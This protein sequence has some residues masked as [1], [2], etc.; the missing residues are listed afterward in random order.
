VIL[1]SKKGEEKFV[2]DKTGIKTEFHQQAILKPVLITN[3]IPLS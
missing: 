1:G 3:R 2:Y